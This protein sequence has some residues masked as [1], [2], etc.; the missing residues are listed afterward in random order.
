MLKATSNSTRNLSL[1][2]EQRKTSM[3]RPI[4]LCSNYWASRHRYLGARCITSSSKKATNVHTNDT[5]HDHLVWGPPA[6]FRQAP[7]YLESTARYPKIAKVQ[8]M[9]MTTKYMKTRRR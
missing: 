1:I 7:Q 9:S 2:V 8:V 5:K 3:K 6:Q 4:A